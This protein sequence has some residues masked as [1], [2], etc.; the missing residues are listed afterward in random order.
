LRAEVKVKIMGRHIVSSLVLLL[1]SIFAFAANDSQPWEKGHFKASA[2]ALYQAAAAVPV[3]PGVDAVVLH[4]EQVSVFEADGRA[5]TTYYLVFK[6]VTQQGAEAWADVSLGWEPWHEE[7]P[8][9]KA[10]VITPDQTEHTLDAKTI[11]DAPARTQDKIYSDRRMLRA[12]LPAMAPGAIVEEE[13]VNQE[14]AP[15]FGAGI[16]DQFYLGRR[17]PVLKAR[18]VLDAPASLPLQYRLEG[19]PDLKPQRTEQNGRVRLVFEA[20]PVDALTDVPEY[21]PSDVTAYP[22]VTFSTGASWQAVAEAYSKI[23]DERIAAADLREQ[24]K[25]LIAGKTSREEKIAA[26]MQELNRHVR[27]TGIEFGEAAIVPHSPTETWNRKYGDCKDK[28]LLLVSLLRAAGVPA[29]IALLNAGFDFDVEA[30]L[31]GMGLFDHAIVYVPGNPDFWIDATDEYARLGQLPAADQGRR[32]LVARPGENALRTIPV[33]SSTDNLLVEKREFYLAESGPARVVE[34]SEPRGSLESS[35]RSSYSDKD[36]EQTKEDLK[37]YVKS[38]YLAENLDRIDRSD[39]SDTSKQFQLVIEAKNARRGF[40]ELDS[41]VVAVRLETLFNRLPAELQRRET[42]DEKKDIAANPAKKRTADYQVGLAFVTEW[43]YS[44]IPPPGFRPKPLPKNQKIAVGP[45]M[46]S[47]DFS[48][49]PDGKVRAIFRFDTTKRRF[50]LEEATELRNKIAELKEG[51]PLFVYFEPLA[52]A[53]Y[54]EGKIRESFQAYR[55]LI[56]L[57]PKE[58]V[59]H[60]QLAKALLENGLGQAARDEAQLAVKLEPSSV[61]A[62]K[63]LADVLQYDL[64]GRKFR[65]G[66]DYAG[67]EAAFRAARKLDPK[68]KEVAGNLAILLEHNNEGERYGPGAKLKEAVAEYRSLTPEELSDIGLKANLAYTLFYAGE[69]ADALKYS[70]TLNPQPKAVMV[71]AVTVL[72]GSDAGLAEARKRSGND[73]EI[74]QVL[75]TAGEILMRMG[76][77]SIAADLMQAGAS[78]SNASQ[79]MALAAMLRKA[80]PRAELQLPDDAK[81]AALGLFLLIADRNLT[82]DKLKSVSSRNAITILNETDADEMKQTQLAGRQIRS[83]LSRTGLPAD[84]LLDLVIPMVDANVEGSDAT[85]NR[86]TL[87][88]PGSKELVLFVVK[89]D[90]RYKLLDSS[91]KPNAIGLEIQD[92]IAA[93]NVTSARQMLDWLR[94]TQHLAGG[95]DP[96]EGRAF[97]RFWTEGKEADAEQMRLAAAAILV[98]TKPA[99]KRGIAIL[100]PARSKASTDTARVNIDLALLAGYENTNQFEKALD[101]V[102]KLAKENPDSKQLFLDQAY[103]LNRLGRWSELDRLAEDRLKRKPQDLDAMRTL[104]RS[105]VGREDYRLAQTLGEKVVAGGKAEGGDLNNLA[106]NSLY[107]GAIGEAEVDTAVRAAQMSQDAPGVLHTLACV[108]A[109]VGKTKEA[110]DLLLQAMD[111]LN[112]DEPDENYWYAFGRI[113]EQYGLREV[114][115]AHYSHVEKLKEAYLIPH[116]SYRLAQMRLKAL[117]VEGR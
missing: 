35:Y 82:A 98:Q 54:R 9:I 32:T 19:L 50:S 99:A 87:R 66:S 110:R 41:A 115:L 25:G 39:P 52:D 92:R 90:G 24:A 16:A 72:N 116:S 26:L 84:V 59:H 12:P 37:N 68:D 103:V 49:D 74:K 6:V 79:T 42:E 63:T 36:N 88:V 104:M 1:S 38:Q 46:L 53:L 95:D 22:H 78:G 45:A 77:Y 117:G 31:P 47:E 64:V 93:G 80:R 94:E 70:E 57:H 107:T 48:A 30:D 21:L 75:K 27:Y 7:H 18:L 60:L 65:R 114:A 102:G 85:G 96:F 23:A 8:T 14:S 40:T 113:A 105:A 20:G 101:I 111:K 61:L 5:T 97:P 33:S 67:A 51:Q 13:F 100:E 106:W 4:E 3:K 83:Q 10:R 108:Y 86:V 89:E 62:Q 2:S 17:V 81:G 11:V 28:S 71:A 91:E 55:E 29:Y 44:I 34:T 15:L 58:A 73:D 109:E 56:A 76:K 112:L 69:Y 43:D